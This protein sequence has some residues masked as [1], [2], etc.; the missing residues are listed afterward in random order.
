MVLPMVTFIV[1]TFLVVALAFLA[2]R[3]GVE[4][5]PGFSEHDARP[6]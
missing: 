5:R 4:Q 2:V 6:H 1:I 3:Y